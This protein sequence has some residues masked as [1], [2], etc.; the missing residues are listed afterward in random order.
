MYIFYFDWVCA[1]PRLWCKVMLVI[2]KWRCILWCIAWTNCSLN[3]WTSIGAFSWQS[4]D[5][6]H[7]TRHSLKKSSNT[8][9]KFVVK[10]FCIRETKLVAD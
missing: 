9:K 1:I 7:Q 4:H 3:L 10:L 5:I 2:L 6:L 8:A